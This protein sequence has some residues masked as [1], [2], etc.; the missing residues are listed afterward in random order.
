MEPIPI[1]IFILTL[2]VLVVTWTQ[3]RQILHLRKASFKDAEICHQII[4]GGRTG[5]HE[6]PNTL[7]PHEARGLPNIRLGTCFGIDNAFT[8]TN[9]IQASEFVRKVKPLLNLSAK[10]WIEVS[11]FAIE[12]TKY[13]IKHGFDSTHEDNGSKENCKETKHTDRPRLNITSLV[14]ILSLKV[15]L[16]QMF[17]LKDQRHL[18]DE[19]FLKL[20]QSINR[21]WISSKL[22]T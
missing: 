6:R 20:A 2:A 21:V 19:S 17:D 7:S 3:L 1:T 18:R 16:W 10:D 4:A 12:T 5:N 8:R 22:S 14:Q 9:R 13:W 11:K 15:M